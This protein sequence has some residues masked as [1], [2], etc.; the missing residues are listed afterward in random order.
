MDSLKLKFTSGNDVP[1]SEARITRQEYED[2]NTEIAELKGRITDIKINKINIIQADAIEKFLDEYL[3]QN[4]IQTLRKFQRHYNN[5][6]F[7]EQL[8]KG[9][10][11]G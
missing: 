9:Q 3:K 7:A 4:K 1:V 5:D 2:I 10:D 6:Y 11:N 8:T